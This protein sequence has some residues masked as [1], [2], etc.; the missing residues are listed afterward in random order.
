MDLEIKSIEAKVSPELICQSFPA[1]L[2]NPTVP[3]MLLKGGKV[4]PKGLY[5][6][7]LLIQI[8]VVISGSRSS[9]RLSS[10]VSDSS[11]HG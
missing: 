6:M 7:E 10:F 9:A 11:Q 1:F 8:S 3:E 4:R 2:R 5:Q